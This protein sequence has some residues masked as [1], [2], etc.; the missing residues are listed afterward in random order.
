MSK[1]QSKVCRSTF[2]AELH[3]CLDA[4]GSACVI[5]AA[6]TEILTGVRTA[7]QLSE[8]QD[9]GGHS[10]EMDVAIDAKSV[11]DAVVADEPKSSDQLVCFICANCEKWSDKVSE[12]SYGWTHAACCVMD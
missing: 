8:L 11:W 10:L 5:N 7:S 12:G 9:S 4:V 3:S 6:L 1:K 2:A